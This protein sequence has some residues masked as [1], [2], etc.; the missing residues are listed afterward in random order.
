MNTLENKQ[1]IQR[2]CNKEEGP[3]T[4]SINQNNNYEEVCTMMKSKTTFPTGTFHGG[5]Q[6]ELPAGTFHGG[7]QR[8]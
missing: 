6:G 2:T 8:A 4:N 7:A 3:M 5:A 1:Q